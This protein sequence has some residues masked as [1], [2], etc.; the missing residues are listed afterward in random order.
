MT[1]QFLEFMADPHDRA[2]IVEDH[3]CY[4]TAVRIEAQALESGGEEISHRGR[5]V[6]QHFAVRIVPAKLADDES[7]ED[8]GCRLR[9]DDLGLGRRVRRLP[10]DRP[11]P[12]TK[13]DKLPSEM[14]TP[15]EA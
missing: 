3:H 11:C 5:C 9:L 14:K 2:G 6:R 13:S 1:K 15:T 4:R 10:G 7:V 12:A 8:D